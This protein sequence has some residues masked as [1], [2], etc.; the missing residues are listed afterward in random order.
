MTCF[1]SFMCVLIARM[2]VWICSFMHMLSVSH[3]MSSYAA[4]MRALKESSPEQYEL[5]LKQKA[6][7]KDRTKKGKKG[8]GVR[9]AVCRCAFGCARRRVCALY[10]VFMCMS[11]VRITLSSPVMRVVMNRGMRIRRVNV[12]RG[13]ERV[14][15]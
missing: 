1:R 9:R 7:A 10:R 2:R 4:E 5:L 12:S 8:K 14:Y 6:A 11:Y 15:G 3:L 13:D